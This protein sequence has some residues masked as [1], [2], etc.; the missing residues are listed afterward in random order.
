MMTNTQQSEALQAVRLLHNAASDERSKEHTNPEM[1]FRARV[2]LEG[3]I[4]SAGVLESAEGDSVEISVRGEKLFVPSEFYQ[5]L[6][7]NGAQP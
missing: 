7:D 3:F 5:F 6:K 2:L 4:K 1:L